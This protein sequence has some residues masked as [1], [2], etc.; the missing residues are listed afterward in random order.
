MTELEQLDFFRD[1]SLVADPYPYM[2]AMRSGCPVRREPHQNVMVVT[3]YDEAVAVFGDAATFSSCTAVTGPFP[4]FPVPIEG[5]GED[6]SEII[7]TYREQLPFSD[8]VTVMDPPKHTE[9]RAL[10]MGLITPKR[11]K[12]NEDFMWEHADTVLEPFLAG[13]TGDY[14]KGFAVPFTLAIIADLLGVPQEDRAEFS[15]KM[16]RSQSEGGIGSTGNSSLSH[17]PLEYLYQKFSGYIEDRRREPRADALTEM[18]AAKFPDGSTP[19][20]MDVVRI[21]A[22]LYSAGQETTVRLLSSALKIIA[23]EPEVQQLLRRE[24]DRIA[25]FIEES[26]RYESP[27]KGDF[28]LAR[29]STTVGGVE[30]PAGATVMVMNGAANRDPRQ[31]EDPETFDVSR[32]NARRHIAFGRGPHSCPGAPLA[33]AE[34]RVSIERILDRTNDIRISEEHHGP[35]DARRYSYV[36]TFILRGLTE[37][38]LEFDVK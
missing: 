19:E 29:R 24:P 7:D 35:A 21:A 26:L 12:Q 2:D 11:L 25:N 13:G 10:L 27:V 5:Q 16:D 37:L 1:Q 23:E 15:R 32:S 36:P 31:F 20:V 3:G 18:A 33:R 28:R 9:H 38:H 4:G 6:V 30:V 34:A 17:T 8:Q 14:I 22:N